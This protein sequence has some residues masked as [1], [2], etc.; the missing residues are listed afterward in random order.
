MPT[1]GVFVP[2][3]HPWRHRPAEYGGPRVGWVHGGHHRRVKTK[4]KHFIWPKDK[5]GGKRN[6]FMDILKGE[7]PDIHVTISA[8]KND[9]MFNRQR[10]ARWSR[11]TNL[12]DRGPDAALK[13]QPPWIE[14]RRGTDM[15]YDFKTRRY[16]RPYRTMWT[17]ALW[18]DEPTKDFQYP[19]A[20]RDIEGQWY[21][22]HKGAVQF[23]PWCD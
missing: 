4:Y 8:D 2:V 17:D 10:K 5:P 21:Q 20:W 6:R 12:D 1:T 3:D 19:Y 15:R 18:G 9:Y 16:R 7:G 13:Y 22:W 11:H 14:G 23:P